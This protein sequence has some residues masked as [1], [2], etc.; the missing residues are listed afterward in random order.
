MSPWAKS[1]ADEGAWS[2]RVVFGGCWTEWTFMGGRAAPG[3]GQLEGQL[4]GGAGLAP[5][6]A[7]QAMQLLASGEGTRVTVTEEE[8]R[9]TP[10]PAAGAGGWARVP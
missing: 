7:G 5:W 9:R 8:N 2:L 4:W 10:E 6:L 3:S 1:N